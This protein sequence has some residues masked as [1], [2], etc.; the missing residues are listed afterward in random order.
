M[1]MFLMAKRGLRYEVWGMSYE[2]WGMSYEVWGMSYECLVVNGRLSCVGITVTLLSKEWNCQLHE[3]YFMENLLQE[4]EKNSTGKFA[5]NVCRY[6]G[7]LR[8]YISRQ[9]EKHGIL[10]F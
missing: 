5:D 2:V 6:I 9:S 1:N 7:A 4:V 8:K 3:K 10:I